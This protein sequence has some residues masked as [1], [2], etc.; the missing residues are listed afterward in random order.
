LVRFVGG[1]LLGVLGWVAI[2]ILGNWVLR[3]VLPGYRQVEE[4]IAF[5]LPMQIGRLTLSLVASL[6]AVALCAMVAG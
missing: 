3:L 2:A 6:G 1:V 4:A 5:T